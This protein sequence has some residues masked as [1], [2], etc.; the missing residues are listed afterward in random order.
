M[1][2]AAKSS[3]I[4]RRSAPAERAG[5]RQWARAVARI[6]I[7]STLIIAALIYLVPLMV[8]VFTSLK[9]DAEI[10]AGN[11]MLPPANPT[12]APWIAAWGEAC[13]SVRCSGL[14]S[15]FANSVAM[16]IPAVLLSVGLGALNGFA[17][18]KWRFP[19]ANLVFFAL[20][21]GCFIPFQMV[22]IPLARVLGFLDLAGSL[23]GL[24]LVHSVYGVCFTTLFFRGFYVG[25]TDE[26]VRAARI[27]GAGFWATF[28]NILLPISWPIIVVSTI[29]QFTGIWNEFL[30]GV[31]FS[32]ANTQPVTVAL[33]N[34]VSTT[35]GTKAY[36]VDMAAAMIAAF[37]TLVVYILAGRF[38]LKGLMSGA[39]KG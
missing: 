27:D 4:V 2:V 22:L 30:F 25:V 8:M 18:T 20:L 11:I 19:G 21:A 26:L 10:R 1:S 9:S 37:P 6:A 32:G 38:F 17:L 29:W 16:T 23:Q 14:S 34:L 5:T 28:W 15:Y 13:I 36:N 3:A 24:V 12:F 35:T 31:T 39:V 33:N 7:Y